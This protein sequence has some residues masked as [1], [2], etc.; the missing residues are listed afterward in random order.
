MQ[1]GGGVTG[2][3]GRH[4]GQQMGRPGQGGGRILQG[5]GLIEQESVDSLAGQNLAALRLAAGAGHGP[6]IAH[7]GAR[8]GEP[9]VAQAET[10]QTARF[11]HDKTL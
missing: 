11:V 5:L 2:L 3:T 7:Q 6:A 4:R 1:E 9:G 8:Q 10:E